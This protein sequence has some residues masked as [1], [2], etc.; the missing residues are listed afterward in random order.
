[1]SV[2]STW[3]VPLGMDRVG[4]TNRFRASH[5]PIRCPNSFIYS[6]R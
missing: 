4:I 3:C 1:M 5:T 2:I 6:T